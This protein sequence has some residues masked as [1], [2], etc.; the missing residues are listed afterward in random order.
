[1]Y[2]VPS[3]PAQAMIPANSSEQTTGEPSVFF[4]GA[5]LTK[6]SYHDPL[7]SNAEQLCEIQQGMREVNKAN[8]SERANTRT[9]P[10]QAAPATIVSPSDPAPVLGQATCTPTFPTHDPFSLFLR[11]SGADP[12]T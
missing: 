10:D 8:K 12:F 7:I 4:R 3:H 2:Q 11:P 5:F 9:D 1:M 6:Q